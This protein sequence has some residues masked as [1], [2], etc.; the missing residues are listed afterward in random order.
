MN[1]LIIG[2][3]IIILIFIAFNLPVINA[4]PPTLVSTFQDQDSFGNDV[5][6]ISGTYNL[7]DN[8]EE[9]NTTL[10]TFSE[11]PAGSI[12]IIEGGYVI[13]GTSSSDSFMFRLFD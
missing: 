12:N 10:W 8:A 5:S 13:E 7:Y 2:I 3:I 1:K 4:A 11:V 6:N 9:K